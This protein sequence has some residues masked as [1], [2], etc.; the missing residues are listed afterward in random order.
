MI[1]IVLTLLL[2]IYIHFGV[3]ILIQIMQSIIIFLSSNLLLGINS[4]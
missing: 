3:L 1:L 2:F 4:F